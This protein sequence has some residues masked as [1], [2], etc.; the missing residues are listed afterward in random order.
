[1]VQFARLSPSNTAL[2]FIAPQF[3]HERQLNLIV[4]PLMAILYARERNTTI[5]VKHRVVQHT[6]ADAAGA[7]SAA[8]T[9]ARTF[10]I[11]IQP[12]HRTALAKVQPIDE[13]TGLVLVLP[14]WSYTPLC[15]NT[16]LAFY[17]IGKYETRF[18]WEI[19]CSKMGT[20]LSELKASIASHA[21]WV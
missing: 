18:G 7:N 13:S 21:C 10:G 15:S 9:A 16:A 2:V 5:P 20:E 19:G 3:E 12:H 1:M 8:A 6:A 4:L 14:S 17:C 11:P